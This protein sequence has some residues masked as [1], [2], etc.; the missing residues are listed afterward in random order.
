MIMTNYDVTIHASQVL[1]TNL[2]TIDNMFD[3]REKVI[4]S[5]NWS[6]CK[7]TR[8]PEKYRIHNFI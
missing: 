6:L 2:S 4:N 5:D 8:R 7:N 1:Q 3:A